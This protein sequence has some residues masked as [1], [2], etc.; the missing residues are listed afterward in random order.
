MG[1]RVFPGGKRPEHEAHPSTLFSAEVKNEW[2]FPSDPH[3]MER[4]NLNSGSI[5]AERGF[6]GH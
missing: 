1:D 5:G 2:S 6:L 4:H 3:G